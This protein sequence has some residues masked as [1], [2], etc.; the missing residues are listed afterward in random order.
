MIKVVVSI[1][2]YNGLSLTKSCL[3]SLSRI[4]QENLDV[5]VVVIDNASQNEPFVLEA[6]DYPKLKLEIIMNQ[7]NSGF[8]GGHNKG[9]AYSQQLNA[10]YTVVLNN[11][12]TLDPECIVNLLKAGENDKKIGIIAP[13]IYFTKNHEYHASRYSDKEK[14]KVIWYAG[15]S[16]DWNNVYWSHRGVDEVDR[17]QYD[18]ESRTDYASGCC[19]AIKNSVLQDVGGFDEAYFL[20]YE[21]ADLN[22]RVKRKGYTINFSPKAKLWHQNAAS[23]GGSGSALQD[24]FTSRNR[25]LLGLKYAP[26]KSKVALI[27]ESVKL[28][29]NGREWQKK[30]IVDYYLRHFGRGRY[31]L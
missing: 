6:K 25:M 26:L 4:N 11:D 16:I 5:T 27:K 30:G 2:N 22:E 13:K 7:E 9:F 12:T 15:G 17:G 19:F 1:L 14:G 23:S 3:D 21:D 29:K 24:Y 10:D 31:P 8:S 28:I 20:Y 18:E